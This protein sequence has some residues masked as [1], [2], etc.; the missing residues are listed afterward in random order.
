LTSGGIV[1]GGSTLTQQLMKNFFLGDERTFKRKVKEALMALIAERKYS[2]EEILENYL[3]EIYLGQRGA[4][5]IFGVWEAA[6]FYFSKDLKELSIGEMALMAG[7][8][9]APNRYSPYRSVEAAVKRRNVVLG[10]MFE[11]GMIT[12]TQYSSKGGLRSRWPMA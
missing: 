9:R 7:L 3:N 8:I 11:T 12:R 2:K 1:Q 4:Q 10:R 6:R 5:G